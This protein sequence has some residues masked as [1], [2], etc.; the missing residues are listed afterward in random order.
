MVVFLF[1]VT[2]HKFLWIINIFIAMMRIKKYLTSCKYETSFAVMVYSWKAILKCVVTL[3]AA[4]IRVP[5][6]R[7]PWTQRHILKVYRISFKGSLCSSLKFPKLFWPA[8]IENIFLSLLQL[9]V[10]SGMELVVGNIRGLGR[11]PV[12]TG[13][14]A[15]ESQDQ[16][17]HIIRYCTINSRACLS[18][19][20]ASM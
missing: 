18:L 20:T 14:C 4:F 16:H 5:W 13:P 10:C 2:I 7:V 8:G 15:F 19:C 1:W 12:L 17:G 6:P 9:T 3:K 11:W